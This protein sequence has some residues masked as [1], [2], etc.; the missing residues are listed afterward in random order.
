[1]PDINYAII[2]TRTRV[3]R[4]LV[5]S[6]EK[7]GNPPPQLAEDEEAIEVP[8]DFDLAVAG[9]PET[10][11]VIGPVSGEMS[12]RGLLQPGAAAARDAVWGALPDRGLVTDDTFTRAHYEAVRAELKRRGFHTGVYYRDRPGGGET[13]VSR[14]L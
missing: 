7:D 14:R 6:L 11:C 10:V 9:D 4:R 5:L 1:M 2:H 3:V 8:K 12:R 13:R